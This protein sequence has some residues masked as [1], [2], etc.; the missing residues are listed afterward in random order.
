MTEKAVKLQVGI[1]FIYIYNTYI[2]VG[3]AMNIN[4]NI[5]EWRL[6]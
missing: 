3:E 1:F 5:R 2:T 4:I 6:R